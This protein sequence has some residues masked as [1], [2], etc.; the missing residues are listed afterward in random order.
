MAEYIQISGKNDIYIGPSDYEVAL[1]YKLG[2]Q[3]DD[4]VIEIQDFT[5]DVPGDRNGGPQGPPIEK[6]MLGQIGRCQLNLSRFDPSVLQLIEQRRTFATPGKIIQAEIG[7]L[8]LLTR[9]WRVLFKPVKDNDPGTDATIQAYDNIDPYV[10]NFVCC[11]LGSPVVL[12]QGTKYSTLRMTFEAHRAPTGH[13]KAD[14]I[15]DR[16][17]TGIPT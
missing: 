4:T 5:I 10:R 15:W 2:E 7:S 9:A 11:V 1:L 3:L 16:D 6:Q 14:V 12:S 17:E 8:M 13:D